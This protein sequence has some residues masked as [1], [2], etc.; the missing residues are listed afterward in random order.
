MPFVITILPL[1]G[2][3]V[4]ANERTE[5]IL[6]GL[7]IALGSAS[8]VPSFFGRHRR[9][10]PLIIFVAGGGLIVLSRLW[11]SEY[12]EVFGVTLGALLIA[13]SHGANQRLN[14]SWRVPAW[15]T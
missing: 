5:W 6:V 13:F 7:S 12:P 8:L 9:A 15:K 10:L 14:Q 11:L 1:V 3:G 4:L 2:L